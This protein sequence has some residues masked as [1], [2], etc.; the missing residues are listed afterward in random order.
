[1]GWVYEFNG[2]NSEDAGAKSEAAKDDSR[3][4]G[5]PLWEVLPC[6]VN[7]YPLLFSYIILEILTPIPLQMP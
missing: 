1:M 6:I 7:W 4:E 5:L 2:N 3:D